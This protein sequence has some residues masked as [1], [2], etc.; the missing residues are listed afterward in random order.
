MLGVLMEKRVLVTGAITH[1]LVGA[2]IT[3]LQS[4]AL[5][6]G[7]WLELAPQSL[8]L[9]AVSCATL[10]LK[11]VLELITQTKSFLTATTC[12]HE[13]TVNHCQNSK[14]L[15]DVHSPFRVFPYGDR[16]QIAG[17]RPPMEIS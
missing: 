12:Q 16:A 1:L 13:F 11:E 2:T 17:P 5:D 3:Q 9:I 14:L 15:A 8:S 4:H 10:W 6:P 7:S